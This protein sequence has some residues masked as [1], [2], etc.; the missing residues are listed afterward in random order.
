MSK[1][2]ICKR[3]IYMQQFYAFRMFSPI[4]YVMTI[5]RKDEINVI[6]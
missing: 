4:V 2:M 1:C 3:T 5:S 6:Q